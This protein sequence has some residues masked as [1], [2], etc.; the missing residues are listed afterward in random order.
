MPEK[1]VFS[2]FLLKCKTDRFLVFGPASAF[3]RYDFTHT[4]QIFR[5]RVAKVIRV[6]YDLQEENFFR[7]PRKNTKRATKNL[8]HGFHAGILLALSNEPS[9]ATIGQPT[10]E[11]NPG[12]KSAFPTSTAKYS[13]LFV[14]STKSCMIKARSQYFG[15]PRSVGESIYLQVKC[16]TEI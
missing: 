2:E 6:D 14:W 10:A 12:L 3:K 16:Q 1:S 8:R 5:R 4:L 13:T 7:A 11:M 15:G 9:L